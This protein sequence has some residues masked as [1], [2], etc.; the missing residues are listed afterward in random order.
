MIYYICIVFY[1]VWRTRN[2]ARTFVFV[3]HFKIVRHGD[4]VTKADYYYC[5][6]IFWNI[7]VTQKCS[8]PKSPIVNY[9]CYYP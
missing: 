7:T 4:S 8:A 3:L 9:M 6:E 2:M 5:I 1:L